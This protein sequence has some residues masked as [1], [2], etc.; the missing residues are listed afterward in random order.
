MK[1]I[2]LMTIFVALVAGTGA[3]SDDEGAANN[4]NNG[5]GADV[6]ADVTSTDGGQDGGDQQDAGPDAAPDTDG[7]VTAAIDAEAQ[8]LAAANSNVVTVAS[9]TSDGPGWAVIHEDDGSG[10]PGPV[11]GQTALNDG[12]NTDVEVTLNRDVADGE[13]LFAMLHVDTGEIGT[14]EFGTD[15]LDGPV[16]VDGSPLT[17]PFVVTR[18]SVTASDKILDDLSTMVTVDSA[19]SKGA[20]WLVIHENACTNDAGDATFGGVIGHAALSDGENTDVEVT[21]ERPATD[22]E[23]LCAMVHVDDPADGAY[24]FDRNDDAPEDPPAILAESGAVVMESFSVQVPEG[25][26]AVRI[27]LSANGTQDYVVDAVAP[28]AFDDG[29]SGSNDPTFQ[30]NENW[31]YEFD[32]TA[33]GGHPFEMYGIANVGNEA[34]ALSQ[35]GEGW[36]EGIE[37]VNWVED[38]NTFRFTVDPDTFA[39]IPPATAPIANYRCVN[40]PAS[41]TGGISVQ[42][43]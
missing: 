38:G 16:V 3:C 10:A 24:T 8:L 30:F 25:T 15:D 2:W 4:G 20:G 37:A 33:T 18:T 28:A 6:G 43:P 1:R 9:A 36:A 31:R 32:N 7:G 22:G 11:L 14:Y 42:S 5:G 21:L 13:T 39:G 19:K 29:L 34:V 40:H 26:P 27:T 12:D 41:M 35:D 23:S 17:D